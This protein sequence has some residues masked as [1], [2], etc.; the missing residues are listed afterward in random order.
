MPFALDRFPKFALSESIKK[1]RLHR[2]NSEQ[3]VG[4][5]IS[6]FPSSFSIL[7][8]YTKSKHLIDS[9]WVLQSQYAARNFAIL[10]NSNNVLSANPSHWGRSSELPEGSLVNTSDRSNRDRDFRFSSFVRKCYICVVVAQTL[11][12]IIINM[13]MLRRPRSKICCLEN[14]DFHI[15]HKGLIPSLGHRDYCL[16]FPYSFLDCHRAWV[17]LWRMG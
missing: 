4:F 1:E 8:V 17:H 12:Q 10:V 6:H 16:I 11:F 15:Y 9:Q 7:Q 5:P 3:F 14:I 13:L 2:R